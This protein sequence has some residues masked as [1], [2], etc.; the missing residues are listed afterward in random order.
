M[1]TSSITPT[2][3]DGDWAVL[4]LSRTDPSAPVSSEVADGGVFNEAWKF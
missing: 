2:L 4:K 3:D 1:P